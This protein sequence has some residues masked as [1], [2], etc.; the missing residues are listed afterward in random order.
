[1]THM[2]EREGNSTWRV[3]KVVPS[4]GVPVY[5]L[6]SKKPIHRFS[7]FHQKAHIPSVPGDNFFFTHRS[8]SLFFFLRTGACLLSSN[9]ITLSKHRHTHMKRQSLRTSTYTILTVGRHTYITYPS[10]LGVAIWNGLE[11]LPEWE[12][13]GGRR[14]EVGQR[15]LKMTRKVMYLLL[16]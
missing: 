4:P 12:G 16:K 1:M 2:R 11:G 14:S 7:R 8:V 3:S 13:Q 6:Q 5:W 9:S 15:L 10:V